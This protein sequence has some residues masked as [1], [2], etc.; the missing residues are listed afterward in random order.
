MQGEGEQTVANKKPSANSSA[1]KCAAVSR[2]VVRQP[3]F[4]NTTPRTSLSPRGYLYYHRQVRQQVLST[5]DTLNRPQQQ[6]HVE[7]MRQS[8]VQ[9]WR[10]RYKELLYEQQDDEIYLQQLMHLFQQWLC[11]E[12]PIDEPPKP[13]VNSVDVRTQEDK[14]IDAVSTQKTP[15]LSA[16]RT[17]SVSRNVTVV[18]DRKCYRCLPFR[19]KR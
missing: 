7:A 8:N 17:V 15:L 11:V 6:P 10:K 19:R 13:D 9:L 3:A 4:P 1:K 18:A 14:A 12:Q 5:L 2:V 16:I